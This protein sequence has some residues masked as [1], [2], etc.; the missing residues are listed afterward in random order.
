MNILFII[1]NLI[2][3]GWINIIREFREAKNEHEANQG[4]HHLK[5]GRVLWWQRVLKV[6]ERKCTSAQAKLGLEPKYYSFTRCET[7][8]PGCDANT[9][10]M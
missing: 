1:Y 6:F 9:C 8:H 7:S 10:Y 2:Y 5:H 4:K 3:H